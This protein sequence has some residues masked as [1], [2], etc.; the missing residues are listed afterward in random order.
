MNKKNI[1]TLLFLS[2][3]LIGLQAI[4]Y[5]TLGLDVT[6]KLYPLISHLPLILLLVFR[7]K[8]KLLSCIYAIT[9]AYLCCQLSKWAGIMAMSITGRKWVFYAAQ[10]VSTLLLF[11]LILQYIASAIALVINKPG[12][13]IVIFGILPV[14]YYLFDYCTTV[15]SHLLY[16]GSQVVCE[17]LSFMY[18]LAFLLFTVVYCRAYEK[19][20]QLEQ[21]KRI[22]DIQIA[23]TKK[24]IEE[25][26]R[27]EHE[28]ALLRH[29]MKH[30][31]CNILSYVENGSIEEAQ[32]YIREIISTTD[33]TFIQKY[34]K[35]QLVNMVLSS[36][37]SRLS[38]AGIR[39]ELSVKISET[40]PCSE[41]DF[42]SIL[43]N[44]LENAMQAVSTLEDNKKYVILHMDMNRDK[45]LLSIKNPYGDKPAMI[46]GIP[47][48]HQKGHG[49]GTQSILAV[50]QRLGGNCQFIAAD[51]MFA[52]RVVL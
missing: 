14:A 2:T 16:S 1:G 22:T 51:G 5:A 4:I 47:V 12:K 32:S 33:K 35:N 43:C 46:D 42:S 8:K 38:N 10:L 17:F 18:C 24:Q 26:Q 25:I 27:T 37:Q 50:T 6:Q 40:L 9:S 31:L 36:Y 29:D 48:S 39:L 49:F 41:L 19:N 3:A 30:F 11:F 23:Q 52:L 45:L 21:Y 15:Y 20:Q 28:I 44:G 34:C 7:Y 13:S